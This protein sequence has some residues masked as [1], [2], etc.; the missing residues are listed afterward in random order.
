MAA[1]EQIVPYFQKLDTMH[2]SNF[3]IDSWIDLIKATDNVWLLS[4]ERSLEYRLTYDM[5]SVTFLD[6]LDKALN[7]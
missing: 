7:G 4:V 6:A 2:F 5:G 1:I 3:A